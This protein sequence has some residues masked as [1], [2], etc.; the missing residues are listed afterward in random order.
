MKIEDVVLTTPRPL[1]VLILADVSGSM[2]ADGKVS[3]LND[4]IAEMMRVF[5]GEEDL[6]AEIHVAVIAFGG[7]T[8][9]LHL[10][11]T[12]A[13]L[14]EWQDLTAAGRTPLGA[15][16]G[17]VRRQIE[18]RE[19][20]PSRAY[21]PTVVLVSDGVP[22]D[23]WEGELAAFKQSDRASKALR[24]ALAI[25]ADANLD[26]LEAFVEGS[27]TP[28]FRASDVP[29]I[30]KFFRLVTMT[31]TARSQSATPNQSVLPLPPTLDE[32]DF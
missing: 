19:R 7:D 13:R 30:T 31:V 9:T 28:V 16:L 8:A 26:V 10:P 20:L 25:G 5:A 24:M 15:A 18:D 3:V 21:R 6:R 4:A 11:L 2:N 32:L 29:Q 14:V 23:E 27:G 17:E 22:T 12:P 1:P